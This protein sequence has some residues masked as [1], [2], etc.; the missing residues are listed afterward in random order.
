MKHLFKAFLWT[1]CPLFVFAQ[2]LT[3]PETT[4]V[5]EPE[6][7]VVTPGAVPSDAIVL[8]N[9]TNLN[10]WEQVKGGEAKWKVENGIVT[11]APGTG[12]IQTKRKFGDIQLHIEW[13]SPNEPETAKGQGRGNS[14]VFLQERYEVQ[15]LNSYQNRTY[16]NGQA[17]S[18]YKQAI[19][20]VNA[21]SKQGD[22]NVYDIIYNAPHF[23]ANGSL[24]K[25]AYVTVLHNGII[26]QN[27]VELQGTTEYVGTPK[28]IMHDKGSIQLQDH[29]NLVSF[30]N[31]WV[32]EL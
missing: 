3:K 31:I 20:L 28:Y 19:P 21:T 29:G 23:R 7:R 15:V 25:P 24:E 30:R 32:R 6:P 11:V 8:F 22:W 1:L 14:G 10:E 4:E 17:A 13:R 5:W 9:G 12:M 18:L 2:D 27:H 16:S 26:V